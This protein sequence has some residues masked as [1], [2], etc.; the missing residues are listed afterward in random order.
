MSSVSVESVVVFAQSLGVLAQ[1]SDDAPPSSLMAL[2]VN[3]KVKTMEGEGVGAR[4][5]LT[6]L[7]G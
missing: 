6:T 4:S 5:L 3:P 2:I 1:S 7:W